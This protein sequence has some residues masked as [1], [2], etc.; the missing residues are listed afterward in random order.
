MSSG[1]NQCAQIATSSFFIVFSGHVSLIMGS[2]LSFS[3]VCSSSWPV[4]ADKLAKVVSDCGSVA[5]KWVSHMPPP[6]HE[7]YK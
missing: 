1:Q 5:S 3:S 4:T 7:S 2:A 6:L